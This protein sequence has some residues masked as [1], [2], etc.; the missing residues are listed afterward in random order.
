MEL[1]PE[2]YDKPKSAELTILFADIR[3][4]TGI[5][6]SLSPEALRDYIDEYLTAIGI[7]VNSGM[8]RVGDMGLARPPCLH[9]HGRRR[10]RRL[11]AGGPDKNL[12]WRHPCRRGY[13]QP[14][15][16]C[17]IQGDRP[18]PGQGQGGGHCHL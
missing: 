9:G 12:R 16:R 11:T 6:E 17:G 5:S 2:R 18:H 8:V 1:D 3:G 7:G 13:A 14:D 15:P 10:K 4:F